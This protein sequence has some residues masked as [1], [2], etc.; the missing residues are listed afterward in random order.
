MHIL[1]TAIVLHDTVT[2]SV[3]LMFLHQRVLVSALL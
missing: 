3:M 2:E 1:T